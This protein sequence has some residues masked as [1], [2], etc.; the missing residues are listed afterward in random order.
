MQ[1]MPEYVVLVISKKWRSKVTN[2]NCVTLVA[3][4]MDGRL[5]YKTWPDTTFASWPSWERLKVG[6]IFTDVAM[7]DKAKRRLSSTSYPRITGH[8][9]IEDSKNNKTK[10]LESQTKLV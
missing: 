2:G 6:D 3:R 10:V 9:D 1:K 5:T 8:I 4:E 7:F